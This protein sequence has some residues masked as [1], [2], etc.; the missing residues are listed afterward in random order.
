MEPISIPQRELR[1]DSAR[2][3]REVQSGHEFVITVRGAPVARLVPER[4]QPT[5]PRTFLPRHEVQDMV[6]RARIAYRGMTMQDLRDAV[7][8]QPRY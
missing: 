1:N 6:G 7:D 3:L 5:G 2:I 8:D 4:T